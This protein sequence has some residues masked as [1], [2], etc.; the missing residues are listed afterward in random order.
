MKPLLKR[1]KSRNLESAICERMESSMC[2]RLG[3]CGLWA[4]LRFRDRRCVSLVKAIEI[5]IPPV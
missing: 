1:L 2:E 3:I 4:V 5:M